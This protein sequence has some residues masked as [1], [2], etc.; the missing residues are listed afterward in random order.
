MRP[1]FTE[2][3]LMIISPCDH[4]AKSG[5]F[6]LFLMMETDRWR[7]NKHASESPAIRETCFP[8]STDGGDSGNDWCNYRPLDY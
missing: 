7:D 6:C 8:A 5:V 4:S 2:I 3:P 1:N